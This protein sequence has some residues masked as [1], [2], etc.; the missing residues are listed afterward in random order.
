MSRSLWGWIA[1]SPSDRSRRR[2]SNKSRALLLEALEA[3]LVPSLASAQPNYMRIVGEGG[4]GVAAPLGS[5]GPTGYSPAQLRHAYGFRPIT[6]KNGTGIG[7]G[8]GQTNPM[9]GG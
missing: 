3:R 5:P 7:H 2:P 1:G 8:S 6:F 4:S 9:R